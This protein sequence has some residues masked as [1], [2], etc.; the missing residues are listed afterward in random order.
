MVKLNNCWVEIDLGAIQHNIKQIVNLVDKSVKVMPIIKA[1]AYGHGLIEVAKACKN[2]G[3]DAFGVATVEEGIR[4]RNEGIKGLILVLYDTPSDRIDQAILY[5]LS[6]SLYSKNFAKVLGN[7]AEKQK[8]KSKVHLAV[9]TGMSWYGL[10]I[11]K[12]LDFAKELNSL[13]AIEIEGI[14]S[15]CPQADSADSDKAF[16]KNQIQKFNNV[17]VE[18]ERNAISLKYCHMANSAAT[19]SLPQSHFNMVRP[20]IMLYGI[21]PDNVDKSKVDLKPA[22]SFKTRII[23]IRD[24]SKNTP[25]GYSGTFTTK[26]NSKIAIL[27]IGYSDGVSRFLSNKGEVIINSQKFPV[28]GN[29]CMNIMMVDITDGVNINTGDEVTILGTEGK[30]SISANDIAKTRNTISYEVLTNLGINNQRIYH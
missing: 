3:I 30:I 10:P 2:E 12:V 1:E 8:K 18:L 21:C 19:I 22:L 23:Q 16:T 9:D 14:Y 28:V 15:H 6:L 20:G 11:D 27:P 7:E 25:I 26:R 17:I 4:L 5:D 13:K 29:V 24:I